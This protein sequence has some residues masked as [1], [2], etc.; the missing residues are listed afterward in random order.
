MELWLAQS[1]HNSQGPG[2][3]FLEKLPMPHVVW[4]QLFA[5]ESLKWRQ[6]I[7]QL[8]WEVLGKNWLLHTLAKQ[9]RSLTKEK[10]LT[11]CW[12]TFCS[13]SKVLLILAGSKSSKWTPA[14]I[15]N[16][17]NF[18]GWLSPVFVDGDILRDSFELL[19]IAFCPDWLLLEAWNWVDWSGSTSFD[20]KT[21]A[22]RS[23]RR[24]YYSSDILECLAQRSAW[25]HR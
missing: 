12:V 2:L 17:E 9:A 19:L 21:F 11:S 13:Q 25:T 16:G 6:I 24:Y 23:I 8:C 4:R 14:F 7:H 18:L 10:I 1:P 22:R 3:I 15:S 5:R 20:R